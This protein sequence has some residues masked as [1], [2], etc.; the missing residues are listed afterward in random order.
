MLS[1]RLPFENTSSPN[2]LCLGAHADD[3]EIGCGGTILRLAKEYPKC[4][5]NWVVFSAEGARIA[6]AQRA[7]RL[8]AGTNALNGPLLKNFR[9]GFMPFDGALVKGVFEELKTSISP[10]LVF[11][12]YCRDAHQ[13]SSARG[14]DI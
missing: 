11:T 5:F 10:D 13:A 7:A 3:V 2:I 12:H 4:I 1:L 14:I 9:D 8:F 6:E